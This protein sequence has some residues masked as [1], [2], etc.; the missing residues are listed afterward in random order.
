MLMNHDEA[1]AQ[2]A[3]DCP[4]CKKPAGERCRTP[5]E[6]VYP[7]VHKMRMKEYRRST[8]VVAMP[9]GAVSGGVLLGKPSTEVVVSPTF[10]DGPS[11]VTVPVVVPEDKLQDLLKLIAGLWN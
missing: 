9:Q 8:A 10:N 3:V 5:N 2:K 7:G 1:A 11:V 6:A 4:R